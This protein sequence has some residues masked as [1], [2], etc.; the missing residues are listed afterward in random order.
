MAICYQCRQKFYGNTCRC[1]WQ[2]E[3]KC[4]SC[5]AKIVPE[6][7][8]RCLH[9]GWFDCP[10]CDKCGCWDNRPLSNEEKEKGLN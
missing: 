3:Y 6:D 2:A 1:G 10:S 4:W 7:C 5:K 9:C 8:N